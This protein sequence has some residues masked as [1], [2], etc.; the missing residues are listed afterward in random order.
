MT[1]WILLLLLAGAEPADPRA[2]AAP[3]PA[4]L[5]D[6]MR[7]LDQTGT[8]PAPPRPAALPP[9]SASPGD[10]RPRPDYEGRERDAPDLAATLV[11]APRIIFFPVHAVA[12]YGLRRPLVFA[13]TAAE[14]HFV[15]TR[16][17]RVF[18]WWDGRAGFFPTFRVDLGLKPVAGFFTFVHGLGHP[19]NETAASASIWNDRLLVVRAQDAAR[20]F[21][22]RTGTLAVSGSYVR[23]PD[24]I[25][26]GIGSD[27][28]NEDKS[29]FFYRRMDVAAALEGRPSGLNR[30]GIDV[31]LR[32]ARFEGSG[33][34][35]TTPDITSRLGGPGQPPLPPG[36]GAGYALIVPRLH[37]V[38]DNRRPPDEDYR[39]SG[40]RLEADGAYAVDPG[41][42][43]T[44]FFSWGA[45]AAALWDFSGYNHVLGA[46]VNVRFIEKLGSNP[47]PF[48]E[49]AS[50]GGPEL[51]RGFLAGRFLGAS[52]VEAT[53]NY[54]Y[55]IWSFADSEIFASVGNAF[56]EHLDGFAPRKLFASWGLSLRS[57]LSRDSSLGLTVAFGSNRFDEDRFR[58][59]DSFRLFLGVN[60]GF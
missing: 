60:E 51:M 25:F 37:V 38:L 34:S 6:V 20:V 7:G 58:P 15:F 40:L 50:L 29:L 21:R 33:T 41:E 26:Y 23:R 44:S 16:L 49:L 36:F 48:T 59:A 11:W 18:T 57:S 52:T 8:P 32:R 39:G 3:E 30:V 22:D 4:A 45:E 56:G 53:L 12:E 10:R 9:P 27:S 31:T 5:E 1:P 54:R 42:T 46:R 13:I 43:A 47:V 35:A 2:P 24:G 19:D 55:P 14:K 17:E 28:R